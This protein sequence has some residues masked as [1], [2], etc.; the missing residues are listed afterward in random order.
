MGL[1]EGKAGAFRQ[2]LQIPTETLEKLEWYGRINQEKDRGIQMGAGVFI[3]IIVIGIIIIINMNKR[4]DEETRK[5]AISS[6]VGAINR[7]MSNVDNPDFETSRS[8]TDIDGRFGI[9]VDQEHKRWM[10][11]TI[12]SENPEFY[13]FNDLIS[14]GIIDDGTEIISSNA[15]NAAIGGILFGTVGA[16]AGA[17]AKREISKTCNDLHIDITVNN[18]QCPHLTLTVIERGAEFNRDSEEYRRKASFVKEVASVLSFIKAN[19][20]VS[21]EPEQPRNETAK[22]N[23]SNDIYDE[24]ERLHGLK[25]NGIITEEEFQKKKEMLLGI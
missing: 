4:D 18:L 3:A 17:S 14:F 16:I 9:A 24:L 22:V 15:G 5:V 10:I 7:V 8:L 23:S 6:N 20:V 2:N 25:E 19:T 11:A 12:K 1:V 21:R 13:N